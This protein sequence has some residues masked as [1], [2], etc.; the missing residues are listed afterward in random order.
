M[1]GWR[2]RWRRGWGDRTL[3][4]YNAETGKLVDQTPTDALSSGIAISP[5][6]TLIAQVDA[7]TAGTS[8]AT[9]GTPI[10]VASRT[11]TRVRSAARAHGGA[12]SR[13][14]VNLTA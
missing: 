5:D 2:L 1:W 4:I 12:R 3:R 6:G 7:L 8:P 13:G 10:S 14:P 11:G 9:N